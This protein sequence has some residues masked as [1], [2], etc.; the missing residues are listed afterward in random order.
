MTVPMALLALLDEGP[1]HGFDLKRRYDALLG[2]ER[3]LKYGQVYSTLQRLERDGLADGVGLEAGGGG[4]RKVYAITAHG[5]T[6]LDQWLATPEPATGR[7]AEVFT[8]VVLAL[9]SGRDADQV[10]DAHRRA[11]LDRMRVLTARRHDGDVVDRLAGDYE[12][13]HL[14]ADLRWIE[15]ASVRLT[16]IAA[17]VRAAGAKGSHP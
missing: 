9:V 11:Y 5:I 6:E 2:H 13:A 1:T 8:R 17:Q 3:E 14:E 10:L 16:T 4:D 12:I 7:P 15:L